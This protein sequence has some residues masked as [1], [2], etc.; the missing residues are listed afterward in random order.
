[1]RVTNEPTIKG[2]VGGQMNMLVIRWVD[3]LMIE[4]T[5]KQVAKQL[6]WVANEQLLEYK[7]I[8]Q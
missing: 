1:M 2:W 3:Y 4:W 7:Y 8:D 6:K 5:T